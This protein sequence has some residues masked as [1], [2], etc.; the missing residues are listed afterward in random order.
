MAEC[1]CLSGCPFFHDK[2]P[3]MP[4]TADMVKNRYCR[5][6]PTACARYMVYR[7]LGTAGVPGDLYPDQTEWARAI[8]RETG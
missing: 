6:D 7:R 4:V 8:L 2:M 1:E 3:G 5:L